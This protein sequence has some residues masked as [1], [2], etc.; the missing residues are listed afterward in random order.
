MPI[1]DATR[2]DS[3]C[4]RISGQA[5]PMTDHG[6]VWRTCFKASHPSRTLL[7]PGHAVLGVYKVPWVT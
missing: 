3:A 4:F 5:V 2:T 7:G 1:A 6:N